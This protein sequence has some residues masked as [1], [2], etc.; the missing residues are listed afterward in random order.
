MNS[1]AL[2]KAASTLLA[3]LLLLYVGYQ[4]YAAHFS[5]IRTEEAY[6]FTASESVQADVL[7]LRKETILKSPAGGV[8]DYAVAEGE[9]V[10]KG[11]TVALVY[12]DEK[13]AAA[14]GKL[15]EIDREIAR[16]RSL[17]SPGST[18]AV[19]PAAANGRI[20]R[21]IT[22]LLGLVNGGAFS[23]ISAGR[24]ELLYQLNEK[25]IVTGKAADFGKRIAALQA[26][27]QTLASQAGTPRGSVAS[28]VSGYFTQTT[29]GL[30]SAFDLSKVP[31]LTGG[32]VR[33]LQAARTAPV[34]GALGKL[35]EDFEWYFACVVPAQE[36]R[37]IK[38]LGE[39]ASVSVRLPFVSGAT[40]PASVAAVNQS[41][42][43][44]EAAVVLRC[45]D[46]ASPLVSVRRE[47]AQIVLREYTG[48]RVSRRAVHY[49]EVTAKKK[50]ESGKT[51]TVKK[52]VPGV[53]ALR[54]DQLSFRQ[55]FPKFSTESYIVCDP[56]PPEDDL[57]TE[58]T[59]KLYD[60]VVVE[61]TDL[62]DGK[63]VE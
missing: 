39:G 20:C 41:G 62:Y 27:R 32:D 38:Q 37:E 51:T 28:P 17:Q 21:Q 16:L 30:E 45:K 44:A 50:D 47:S 18:F 56:S 15:E 11:E 31:A 54:G 5:R 43:D 29:D 59:V 2:R 8:V 33:R 46:M 57:L 36:A 23:G 24:E 25:Q 40:V 55:I 58:S 52:E 10:A 60:E 22:D 12:A 48:V 13:Q 35:C 19:S 53:Y 1:P 49:E 63:V 6:Y 61:G 3:L 9:K 7:A 34:A 14:R 26:Q 42:A 4:I